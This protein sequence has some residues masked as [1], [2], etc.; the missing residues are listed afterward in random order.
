VI[1][2]KVDVKVGLY[3]RLE[4]ARANSELLSFT[5]LKLHKLLLP[6]TLKLNFML[7]YR[8]L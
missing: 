2:S 8:Q 6:A 1:T 3:N 5:A 4:G 7:S